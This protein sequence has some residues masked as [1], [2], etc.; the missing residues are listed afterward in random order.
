M[1]AW[2]VHVINMISSN[3]R[4]RMSTDGC[5]VDNK[6][7]VPTGEPVQIKEAVPGVWCV[8]HVGQ[9][10]WSSARTFTDMPVNCE[11]HSATNGLFFFPTVNCF[12]EV[13]SPSIFQTVLYTAARLYDITDMVVNIFVLYTGSATLH[14]SWTVD[15]VC[16]QDACH[17][18]HHL[19]CD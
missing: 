11:A 17:S 1:M 13:L 4:E 5:C 3:I 6:G 2:L 9:V 8:Q 16:M 14:W 12:S 7:D 15:P 18:S 10:T 19:C